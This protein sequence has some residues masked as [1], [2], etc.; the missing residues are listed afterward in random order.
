MEI[1]PERGEFCPAFDGVTLTMI[2]RDEVMNPAGGL[3]STITRHVNYFPET[4]V[5][6][7]GSRDGTKHLLDCLSA[8]FPSMRVYYHS[9]FQGYGKARN[10]AKGMVRTRYSFILDADEYIVKG[11]LDEIKRIM[12]RENN[13]NHIGEIKLNFWDVSPGIEKPVV[14]PILNI[15]FHEVFGTSFNGHVYE[16]LESGRIIP[17]AS[18]GP[19]YGILHFMPCGD[20]RLQKECDWY[21]RLTSHLEKRTAP[22]ETRSFEAWKTPDNEL[23]N[24]YGIDLDT[25]IHGLKTIGL[26]VPDVFSP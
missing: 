18:V 11:T 6:D 8:R 24:R 16:H 12:K 15:R 19:K 1:I 25:I 17:S 13:G 21:N 23:L 22:S 5:L 3:F 14:Y 20:G 7:T 2:V 9:D 4:V 10:D 26:R